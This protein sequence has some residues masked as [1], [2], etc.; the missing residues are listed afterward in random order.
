MASGAW[1]QV[2]AKPV[3]VAIQNDIA[4]DGKGFEIVPAKGFC[5]I[6]GVFRQINLEAAG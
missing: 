5:R 4:R 2:H 3:G 1:R 6:I